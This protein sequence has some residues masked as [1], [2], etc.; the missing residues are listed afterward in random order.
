MNIFRASWFRFHLGQRFQWYRRWFGGR[1]ELHW[2]DICGAYIWLPMSSDPQRQWPAYR[3]PCS[4]G[5]PIIEDY[6]SRAI[7][8][9]T[10]VDGKWAGS[11]WA[12][13]PATCGHPR[14]GCED[15]C[16]VNP[17]PSEAG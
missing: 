17:K 7:R 16:A 2:I 8:F 5:A 9:G 10:Y 12:R 3:Q 14:C 6:S 1:W 13:A 15:E 4:V 11:D